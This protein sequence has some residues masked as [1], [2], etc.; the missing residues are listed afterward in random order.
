MCPIYYR[1]VECTELH[2]GTCPASS[3]QIEYSYSGDTLTRHVLWMLCYL[4]T[5]LFI[6]WHGGLR[7][8]NFGGGEAVSGGSKLTYRINWI[9]AP[10]SLK[11]IITFT[12]RLIGKIPVT[13]KL[14]HPISACF[15]R[16]FKFILKIIPINNLL[17]F[18]FLNSC[19]P[20]GETS[21]G[22]NKLI[23]LSWLME[24]NLWTPP[25]WKVRSSSMGIIAA[26]A[27]KYIINIYISLLICTWGSCKE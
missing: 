6:A 22:N 2:T 3:M 9:V 14:I 10:S 11:E 4:A 13:F 27:W 24:T 15:F 21:T 17:P 16:I 8:M 5:R 12:Y 26:Q 1:S 25:K 20:I 23:R 7:T 19:F 18:E